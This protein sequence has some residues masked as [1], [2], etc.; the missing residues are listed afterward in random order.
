VLSLDGRH[1]SG[2]LIM[3]GYELQKGK[4]GGRRLY[5]CSGL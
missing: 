3:K 2:R 1:D 4:E 5:R